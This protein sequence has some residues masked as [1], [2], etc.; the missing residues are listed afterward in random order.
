M[1]SES[2][3]YEKLLVCLL[4][5]GRWSIQFTEELKLFEIWR[6]VFI[7][8]WH[9]YVPKSSARKIFT[10]PIDLAALARPVCVPIAN[11]TTMTRILSW[12][13]MPAEVARGHRC[14]KRSAGRN[15]LWRN[16]LDFKLSKINDFFVCF[17]TYREIHYI[18]EIERGAASK[19]ATWNLGNGIILLAFEPFTFN[20]TSSFHFS[21]AFNF[22]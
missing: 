20:S 4:R 13:A 19:W 6:C 15:N 3:S 14:L 8:F 17:Q 21:S 5:R 7:D 22:W 16:F 12:L 18:D 2:I 10:H 1:T 11:T 9:F